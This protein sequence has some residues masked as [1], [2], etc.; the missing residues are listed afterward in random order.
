[1]RIVVAREPLRVAHESHNALRLEGFEH[2][3]AGADHGENAV[4]LVGRAIDGLVGQ[5]IRVPPG[6][7]V[8]ERCYGLLEL[9]HDRVQALRLDRVDHGPVVLAKEAVRLHAVAT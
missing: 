6:E 5:D 8:D 2:E 4:R 3:G 1:M 9:D 7:E